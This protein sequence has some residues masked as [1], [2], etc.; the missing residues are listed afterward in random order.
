MSILDAVAQLPVNLNFN[1]QS[2]S[3]SEQVLTVSNRIDTASLPVKI[4]K[5]K[6]DG[7]VF[8]IVAGIHGYEYPPIMAVQQIMAEIDP[9]KL[10]GTLLIVPVANTTAFFGRTVFYNPADGKNLNRVFPGKPD[11]TISER[12]AHLITIQIITRSTVFLDVHAGDAGED[13][14][15]FVCYYDN[16]NTPEQTDLAR[17]LAEGTGFPLLVTYPFNLAKTEPAEYAFKHAT[18]QGITALSMEA[19]KLGGVQQRSVQQIKTGI[20]NILRELDMY[21]SAGKPVP[22]PVI[23]NRQ[24]YLKSPEK[25][26]FYS[27]LKSGDTVSKGQKIGMISDVFGKTIADI[28]AEQAGII[29]YKI[30][31]PPVNKGETILCIGYHCTAK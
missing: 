19:G 28:N 12:L 18:Q 24:H 9:D 21:A 16:K 15:D 1:I 3:T 8:S 29:L 6:M 30:G 14:T 2:A 31:T 25:G 4:I 26:I 7:P 10:K 13:L 5:G 22:R 17:R 11:G 20:Y 23:L 27:D